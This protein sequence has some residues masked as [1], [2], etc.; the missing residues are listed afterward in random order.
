MKLFLDTTGEDFALALYKDNFELLDYVYIQNSP[1]KVELIPQA[2]E[3]ILKKSHQDINNFDTFYVNLGPGFFTGVRI[4]LVYLR[5]IALVTKADIKTIS[6]MQ[7]LAFQHPRKKA[8]NI[9]ARGGKYYHYKKNNKQA[10]KTDQITLCAGDLAK[11]DSFNYI[12]LIN[13]FKDYLSLFKSYK[14]L[15]DIN[16][17]YIK[18]PQIGENK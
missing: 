13:N 15:M 5:T 7:V 6:T 17:Y 1:K 16:P 3:E 4:S 14:D 12:D 9:N 8:F 18:M 10:F 2:V 11:Y